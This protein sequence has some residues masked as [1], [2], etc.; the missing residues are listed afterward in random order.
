MVQ[1]RKRTL[2]GKHIP[3]W[4]RMLEIAEDSLIMSFSMYYFPKMKNHLKTTT[5]L[6]HTCLEQQ[7]SFLYILILMKNVVLGAGGMAW[8]LR[9]CTVLVWVLSSTAFMLGGSQYLRGFNIL[10]WPRCTCLYSPHG[11]IHAHK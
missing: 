7:R 11:Y 9:V 6:P 10:F 3:L 1:E 4:I 2:T 5:K 8:W